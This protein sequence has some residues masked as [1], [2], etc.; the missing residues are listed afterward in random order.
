MMLGS[1]IPGRFFNG[2]E[3]E[4]EELEDDDLLD[5]ADLEL[6]D[7]IDLEAELDELE[8][9]AGLLDLTLAED[10]LVDDEGYDLEDD[11]DDDDLYGDDDDGLDDDDDEDFY[12]DEYEF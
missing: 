9:E 4:V 6:E 8:V 1:N 2:P 12:E 11:D 5:D 3:E 10:E 7:D